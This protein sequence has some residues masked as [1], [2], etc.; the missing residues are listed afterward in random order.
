MKRTNVYAIS[1]FAVLLSG[2]ALGI[3]AA[4]DSP[5][6][7]MS[8]GD[9]FEGRR[10][11]WTQTRK[12]LA[13]CR[14][15]EGVAKDICKAQARADER[16]KKADLEARYLGT[17]AAADDA[18]IART[19]ASFEVARARCG[20]RESDERADCLRSARDEQGKALADSKLASAT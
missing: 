4:V 6:T 16:V 12:A 18:R 8:R 15:S 9:Y 19:K 2:A 5:R 7:L 10:A 20:L 13:R 17:V 11:I 1:F 14:E 3:G